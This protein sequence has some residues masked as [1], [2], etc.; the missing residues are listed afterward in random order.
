M[1]KDNLTREL[2]LYIKQNYRPE[3]F[4]LKDF[5]GGMGP[6]YATGGSPGGAKWALDF[7]LKKMELSFSEKLIKLIEKKGRKPSEVYTKAGVT[8]AHFSKIKADSGYHPK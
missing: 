2:D 1:R 3:G 7:L 4:K 5:I 6:T 8:K